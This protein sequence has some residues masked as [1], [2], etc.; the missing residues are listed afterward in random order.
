MRFT[1]GGFSY[2]NLRRMDLGEY[3]ALKYSIN[4]LIQ[5]EKDQYEESKIEAETEAAEMQKRAKKRAPT[6]RR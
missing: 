1:K 5:E 3:N 4:V 2:D 6:R